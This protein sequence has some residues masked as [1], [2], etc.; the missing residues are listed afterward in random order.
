[1]GFAV[2]ALYL[3]LT[4]VRPAELFPELAPYRVMLILAGLGLASSL[5]SLYLR[6]G[7]TLNRA[8]VYLV[9]GFIFWASVSV[10][11]SGWMGGGLAALEHLLPVFVLFLLAVINVDT[12]RR[13]RITGALLVVLTM[14]TVAQ[15]I[16]AFHFGIGVESFLIR[17]TGDE[18]ADFEAVSPADEDDPSADAGEHSGATV[19][20]IRGLGFLN[21]PNDLAQCIV[22]I[23]PFVFVQWRPQQYLRNLALVLVPTAY[24]LYGAFLTRSRGGLLSALALI[25]L[26]LQDRVG[27]T[28]SILM[29][30]GALVLLAGAS[31]GG[32]SLSVDQSALDRLEAWRAGIDMLRSSPLWGVGYGAFTDAHMRVAHNSYVHCFAETG[33][34]GY[35]LWLGAVA[36]TLVEL[37]SLRRL[38]IAGPD[39]GDITR[40]A[41]ALRGSVVAFLAAA[42]FLSRT[43]AVLL[44][45]LLALATAVIGI[46]RRAQAPLPPWNPLAWG[47]LIGTIEITSILV[48]WATVRAYGL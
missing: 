8:Q 26:A 25:A 46:G 20:R 35:F 16:A 47:V 36:V 15:G 44:F 33:L 6:P 42:F 4:F 21:D 5:V 2:F 28:A 12:L 19:L 13:L 23:L 7:V 38:P 27:R 9:L 14:L 37:S 10:V 43:Y 24:L 39:G 32:R 40:W 48:V 22:S 17:D 1:M 29:S 41:S 31:V 34:V 18:N 11:L 45:L 3:I 30:G